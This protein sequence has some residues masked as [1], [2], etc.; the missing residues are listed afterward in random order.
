MSFFDI[1]KE[2]SPLPPITN[3]SEQNRLYRYWRLRIL[4]AMYIGYA[5]YYLTRGTLAITMPHLK[6]LGY[7]EVYLGWMITLFQ[8]SYGISKFANGILA[9]RTNPKFFMAIGIFLSGA[10]SIFFGFTNSIISF[11][12]FW[13]LN[14]WFQGFGSAPCHKLLSYWYSRSER[15]RWWSIWNTSH[16]AG[17]A[18]LPLLGAFFLTRFG[19]QSVMIVPGAIA[20]VTGLF[21][22]NRLRD[23]PE[24][25]GLPSIE[26]FK[27]DPDELECKHAREKKASIKEILW[28]NVLKNKWV[29]ILSISY[30]MVYVIRWTISNWAFHFL[31][32]SRNFEIWMA[33]K[34]IMWYE[35]GGFVGGIAAGYLSDLV[36]KGNRP[37]VN[38]IFFLG[39]IPSI[40]AF[41]LLSSQTSFSP[42]ILIIM[43]LMGFFIFG[44]QMLLAVH[45]VEI[46]GKQASA[47]SV[48]FLGII[49]YLGS[50]VTGG[51][52]GYLVKH[53]GWENVFFLLTICT[54]LASITTLP[55]IIFKQ[56]ET[57]IGA[58]I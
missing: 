32:D 31:V 53:S 5:V 6:Q 36:F 22:L 43:A 8:I 56:K 58:R 45:A 9:D 21:L 15:G 50:A 27:G 29:W 19:W 34:C 18:L 40:Y 4:Y 39:M 17:A 14:G 2:S 57:K 28:K 7:D 35:I 47:T 30:F 26:T 3:P 41:S 12:I 54:I 11:C 23:T 13:V 20:I 44:P 10:V 16:N 49:A 33:A 51:P 52:L 1:F 25:M 48:G 24:S 55:F 46:C 42:L 38:F 37:I